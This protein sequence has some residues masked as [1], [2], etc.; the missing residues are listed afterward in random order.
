MA[1]KEKPSYCAGMV[2]RLD[3]DRFLCTLFAPPERR[4]A[5][6]AL[7]AFNLE[8]ARIPELVHEPILGSV[9]LQWWRDTV[10]A[11]YEGRPPAHEVALALAR[12]VA[13][14]GLTRGYFD[15]LLEARE[16]DF[17]GTPPED[18]EALITYAGATSATLTF[19]ALEILDAG[20]GSDARAAAQDAGR[21]VGIAWA[22]T[23]LIRAMPYHARAGRVY[24][25]RSLLARENL[26]PAD[27]QA[28]TPGLAK[29]VEDV[30]QSARGFLASARSHER[31]A[32][33][34]ARPALLPGVLASSYLSRIERA[35]FDPFDLRIEGGGLRRQVRLWLAAAANGK[36]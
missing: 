25:P 30:A 12:A 33:D 5:L 8:V 2:R 35:G 21:D 24:L 6:F 7:Y 1:A 4:E 3:R 19:L 14:Y 31:A 11:I 15:R 18:M 13:S 10:A 34:W 22:L 27:L 32:P 29:V 17:G 23:G 16:F 26:R 36:L 20:G 9:R 28:F